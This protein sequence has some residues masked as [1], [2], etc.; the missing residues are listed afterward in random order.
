MLRA[1]A[2]VRPEPICLDDADIIG[3]QGSAR[4]CVAP[5]GAAAEAEE[6]ATALS[7]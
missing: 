5:T 7:G 6:S 4:G 2:K 3:F 1:H